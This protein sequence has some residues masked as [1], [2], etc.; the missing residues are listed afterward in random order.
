M[1][2]LVSQ[3]QNEAEELKMKGVDIVPH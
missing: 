2:V 1:A 3:S